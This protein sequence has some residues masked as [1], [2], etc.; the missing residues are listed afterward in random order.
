MISSPSASHSPSHAGAADL[1]VGSL[2]MPHEG[3]RQ[4]RTWMA[5]P[6]A[7]YMLSGQH[8]PVEEVWR[9]WAAVAN[10]ISDYQPVSILVHPKDQNEA[11]R[12]LSSA[13]EQHTELID[14][15]WMRD[16]GPTF[17]RD[18]T[19]GALHAVSWVF[20]AWGGLT[21]AETTGDDG[22]AAEVAGILGVPVALS[23]LVNEGG[24][25]H[26]DGAGTVL[27]TETVQL[28]PARNPGLTKAD[29]EDEFMR[30]LGARKVIWLPRGLHRDY[31]PL[32]T[33]GHVDMVASFSTQGAVL[34]HAQRDMAH[35]DHLLTQ[36]L[37]AQLTSE[38]DA[39]G[40]ALT[41]IDLPAPRVLRDAVG[42]V[43]YSYVNHVLINGAVIACAFDDPVDA[44]AVAVLTEAYPGRDIVPLD[45]RAIFALGG[46]IHCITQQQP[47]AGH[48]DH[49]PNGLR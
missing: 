24:G 42:W 17:V 34:L 20:N 11:R 27:A 38:S 33:R 28:D 37:R 2:L 8:A 29:V 9:A 3:E 35:P 15:A 13:V 7:D 19:T 10:S 21:L 5:W 39:L 14:D 49:Q 25:I 22:V 16:S 26:V 18:R 1:G 40:G 47:A 43:D 48:V 4:S 45:A 46:G 32:G 12:F 23:P 30:L 41:V 36:Q 44:E 6:T 31:G